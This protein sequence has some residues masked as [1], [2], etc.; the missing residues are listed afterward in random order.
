[1]EGGQIDPAAD[2]RQRALKTEPTTEE[3][4]MTTFATT[5]YRNVTCAAAAILITTVVSLSFVQSTSAA[6]FQ[7]AQ[8]AV[9]AQADE[10]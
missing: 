1:M 9:A 7:S 10:A 4:T 2:R 6:P 8:T 3:M 5:L